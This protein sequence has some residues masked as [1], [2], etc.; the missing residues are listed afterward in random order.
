MFEATPDTNYRVPPIRLFRCVNIAFTFSVLNIFIRRQQNW[1][2]STEVETPPTPAPGSRPSRPLGIYQAG[3]PLPV[4]DTPPP[5]TTAPGSRPPRPL[6]V[7][8][9]RAPPPVPCD[10]KRCCHKIVFGQHFEINAS[11]LTKVGNSS[12]LL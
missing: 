7:Q 2:A 11:S 9:V 6:E 10:K 3:A 12:N 4:D 1:N 5:P 8:Q